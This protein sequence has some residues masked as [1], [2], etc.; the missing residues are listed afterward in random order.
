LEDVGFDKTTT[1]Q[2]YV[3]LKQ[4][5]ETILPGLAEYPVIQQWAGLRP[6]SP[7]GIPH[8]GSV[9]GYENLFI[10]AGHFRNGVVLAPGSVQLLVEKILGESPSL[11]CK[12]YQSE[13][14]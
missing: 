8:I 5:A 3:E 1:E 14:A 7:A 11:D 6:A 13:S 4:F 10:N 2:A 12:P 9:R